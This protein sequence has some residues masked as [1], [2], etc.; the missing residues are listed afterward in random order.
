MA[1]PTEL[2]WRPMET[3]PFSLHFLP[4]PL[5]PFPLP[6]EQSAYSTSP[7]PKY[8]HSHELAEKNT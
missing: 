5:R 8:K 4:C 2:V 1:R 6:S 7:L 3:E